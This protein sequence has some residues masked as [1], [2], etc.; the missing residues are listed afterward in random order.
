MRKLIG[1]IPAV[2]F[3]TLYLYVWMTGGSFTMSMVILW[4]VCLWLSAFFLHKGLFWGGIF[5]L[6]PAIHMIYMGTQYTG[7]V[8]NIEIPL[9]IIVLLFL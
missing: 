5:G 1:Y 2:L 3:T 9:G 4:I 7:Q 8:I 6:I